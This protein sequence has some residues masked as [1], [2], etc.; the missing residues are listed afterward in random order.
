MVGRT[1]VLAHRAGTVEFMM[2]PRI[3][4]NGEQLRCRGGYF[5]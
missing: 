5:D 1:D 2:A 3:R 4:R